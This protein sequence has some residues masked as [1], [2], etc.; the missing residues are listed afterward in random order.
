MSFGY[1]DGQNKCSELLHVLKIR[2]VCIEREP[3][4]RGTQ[5][6]V[7]SVQTLYAHT[8]EGVRDK[9]QTV[10]VATDQSKIFKWSV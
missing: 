3:V 10:F 2:R 8:I 7:I 4:G 5:R 9:N 6:V 1:V